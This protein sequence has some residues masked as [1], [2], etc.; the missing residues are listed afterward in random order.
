MKEIK[1]WGDLP[2]GMLEEIRA[3]GQN[4]D[5]EDTKT[6]TIAGILAGKTFKEMLN[7]P[8]EETQRL[9]KN[10][11][12]L[13]TEPAKKKLSSVYT[14]N[15]TKYE[16]L[17]KAEKMTTAQFIDYQAIARESFNRVSE[18]LAIFFIPSGHEY[19]DG[20]Y[21]KQQV[22]DDIA[23]Y[24]STEEALGIADFF[25]NRCVRLMQRTLLLLE[26]KM[27]VLKLGRKDKTKMIAAETEKMIKD[28]RSIYGWR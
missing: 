19:N 12:F 2:V 7:L 15:G 18:F 24:L 23:N 11:A 27:A 5:D 26:A 4:T 28:L 22:I 20:K 10:T 6:L 9:I 25:I 17:K 21:D 3:V 8:L 13:Y 14:L 1:S 16:I